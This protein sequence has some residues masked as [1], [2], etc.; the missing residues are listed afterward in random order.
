MLN[1]RHQ[2]R[3]Q[4]KVKEN[5]FLHLAD[6]LFAR[7]QFSTEMT[8]IGAVEPRHAREGAGGSR[9]PSCL[10]VEGAGGAKVPFSNAMICFVI[11][12]MIQQRL[13]KL[14]ASNI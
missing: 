11:V 2:G 1:Q 10:S 7:I 4:G 3:N 9:C 12:S 8:T 6:T 14:K 5:D 13:Y